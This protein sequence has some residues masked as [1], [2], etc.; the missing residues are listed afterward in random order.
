MMRRFFQWYFRKSGDGHHHDRSG[1]ESRFMDCNRGERAE[2]S[3]T[4][5]ST[6]PDTPGPEAALLAPILILE[7][8]TPQG[9]CCVSSSSIR[10]H[11]GVRG[12]VA[13][14]SGPR[15]GDH[16]VTV[17]VSASPGK[18]FP[19]EMSGRGYLGTLRE[20]IRQQDLVGSMCLPR[21]LVFGF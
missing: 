1:P 8:P 11:K 7:D 17:T 2:S 15:D 21:A 16:R 19:I 6:E 14:A 4:G 3:N 10:S 12:E 20:P 5:T 18:P 13:P 9:K